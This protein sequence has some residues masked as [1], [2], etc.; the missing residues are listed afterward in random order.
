MALGWLIRF[1]VLMV[2]V[3]LGWKFL[4]GLVEGATQPPQV[5]PKRGVPLVRDPVCGTYVDS[6]RA[7]SFRTRSKVYYFCSEDCLTAY[8]QRR[9][10][11][12]RSG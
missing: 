12:A 4:V 10:E 9:R 2:L 11:S 7:L 8:R 3:R 6:G 1:L 5:T